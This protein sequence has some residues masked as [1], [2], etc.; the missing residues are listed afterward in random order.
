VEQSLVARWAI[1]QRSKVQ[2]SFA[3][4]QNS[5]RKTLIPRFSSFRRNSNKRGVAERARCRSSV[6][7]EATKLTDILTPSC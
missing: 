4:H 6:P 3:P 5:F 2:E 1:R 7:G